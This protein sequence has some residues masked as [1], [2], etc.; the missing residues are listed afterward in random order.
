[1]KLKA[2]A[3]ESLRL[4]LHEAFDVDVAFTI[5]RQRQSELALERLECGRRLQ[6]IVKP[7]KLLAE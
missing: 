1:M 5:T 7:L 6:V 3:N 2:V 4:I